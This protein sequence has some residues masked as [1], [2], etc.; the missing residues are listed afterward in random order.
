MVWKDTVSGNVVIDA[1][2]LRFLFVKS[3]FKLLLSCY[4]LSNK[5]RWFDEKHLCKSMMYCLVNSQYFYS[6][7]YNFFIQK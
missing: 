6:W 2:W 4:F 1:V 3:K 5:A 7:R